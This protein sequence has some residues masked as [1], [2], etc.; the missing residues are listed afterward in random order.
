MASE[1]NI[2]SSNGLAPVRLQAITWIND[3]SLS[4]GPVSEIWIKI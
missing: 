2:D 3:E 1:T 4:I